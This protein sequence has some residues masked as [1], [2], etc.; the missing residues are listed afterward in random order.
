[1]LSHRSLSLAIAIIPANVVVRG[2]AARLGFLI[3]IMV[4]LHGVFPQILA[5]LYSLVLFRPG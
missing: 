5:Y 2:F 3:K 1:M 4:R